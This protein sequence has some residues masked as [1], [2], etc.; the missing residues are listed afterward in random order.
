[1][2]A[3]SIGG[4]V[5]DFFRYDYEDVEQ[6]GYLQAKVT[7]VLSTNLYE[8]A[9]GKLVY[10]IESATTDKNTEYNSVVYKV[11]ENT[12]LEIA[13]RLRRDGLTH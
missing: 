1:M 12:S 8:T 3:K 9:S 2:E 5:V 4:N 6:P 10:S 13:R 7:V 11:I